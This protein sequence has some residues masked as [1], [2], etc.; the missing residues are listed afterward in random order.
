LSAE[1]DEW[2]ECDTCGGDGMGDDEDWQPDDD[3]A[4][5]ELNGY[6]P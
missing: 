6:W 2:D 3:E 1:E 5:D 4:M